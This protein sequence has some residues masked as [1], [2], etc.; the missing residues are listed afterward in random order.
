MAGINRNLN[1]STIAVVNTVSV[2]RSMSESNLDEVGV[3]Q[4]IKAV[5][6][7]KTKV[8]FPINYPIYE[9]SM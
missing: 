9:I 7:T 6:D 3:T 1:R 8:C 5:G 2:R 4:L